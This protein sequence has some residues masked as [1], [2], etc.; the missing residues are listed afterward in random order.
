MRQQNI[1]QPANIG[2]ENQS[3]YSHLQG[4][5]GRAFDVA[6]FTVERTA[7]TEAIA[8]FTREIRTGRDRRLVMFAKATLP[9]LKM[10]LAM[11]GR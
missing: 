5:T 1:P 6:Y 11:L 10:H 3:A 4:L 7:H 2:P 9:V 8:L